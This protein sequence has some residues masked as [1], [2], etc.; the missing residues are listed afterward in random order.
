MTISIKRSFKAAIFLALCITLSSKQISYANNDFNKA[1]ENIKAGNYKTASQQLQL[2]ANTYPNRAD[3]H[4]YLASSLAQMNLHEKAIDEYRT[5]YKLDPKGESG[6]LAASMLKQ[7]GE[8]LTIQPAQDIAYAL[9]VQQMVKQL[10]QQTADAK[11][12][13]SKNQINTSTSNSRSNP[14]SNLSSGIRISGDVRISGGSVIIDSYNGTSINSQF[15]RSRTYPRWM[16]P[17][18]RSAFL[19]R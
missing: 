2:L 12:S 14:W 9:A 1:L 11:V 18:R 6:K 8:P 3:I 16:N 13:S 5:A 10:R 17:Q 4:Y 15:N 7:Y 19:S